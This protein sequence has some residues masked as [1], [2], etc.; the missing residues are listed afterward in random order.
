[1][2]T[3]APRISVVVPVYNNGPYIAETLQRVLD[4]T[5]GDYEIVVTD[6]ASA[7][8]SAEI[9]ASFS[10]PRIRFIRNERNAGAVPNWNRGMAEARGRYVKLLCADDLLYPTCLERQAAVL[11]DPA[12]AGVALVTAAHDVVDEGGKRIMVRGLR[13][14]GCMS[15]AEVIRRIARSGTNH[16]GEPSGVMFRA[17]AYRAVGPWVEDARYV[18][19]L[20]MWVRLLTVGDL[21]VVG[22]TLS[23]F[24]VQRGSWSNALTHTQT[25]DMRRLLERMADDGAYGVTRADATLGA[26]GAWRNSLMR[27]VF[28][29]VFLRGADLSRLGD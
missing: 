4:Q 18:V 12:N 11:D 19:D 29:R 7:D 28:Y 8:R 10:D 17:D 22:E 9:V 15:G 21:Y 26:F 6:D 13:S 25:A 24:R 5:V 14:E 20:D 3:D 1:V 27:R 23:A 2:S 16:I